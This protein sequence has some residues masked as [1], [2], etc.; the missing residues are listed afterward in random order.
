ME[1]NLATGGHN[2]YLHHT[3][4]AAP[5]IVPRAFTPRHP[6][7]APVVHSVAEVTRRQ[8]AMVLPPK[9]YSWLP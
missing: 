2:V 1:V 9:H 6:L 4:R 8:G 5:T 7:G 3:N